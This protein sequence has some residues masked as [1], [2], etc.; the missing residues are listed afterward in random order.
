MIIRSAFSCLTCNQKHVVRIGMG[1]EEKQIH[2]F[3]CLGCGEDMTIQLIT[4]YVNIR[5]WAEAVENAVITDEE[6]GIP[7]VNLEAN[8]LI[9][10]NQ[11]NSDH[12]FPRMKQMHEMAKAAEARG[13]DFS[14]LPL[15]GESRLY[16]PYRRPDYG[17]E[18]MELKKAWSLSLRKKER[19]AKNVLEQASL[20]YYSDA[21]PNGLPDWLWR[22]GLF[23]SER[24]HGQSL[25]A[26]LEEIRPLFGTKSMAAFIA[27]YNGQAKKRGER[28]REILNEYF[29][30]FSEFGQVYFLMQ[31]GQRIPNENV[32]S[33]ISF[34]KIRMFYGN[35]FELFSSSVDIIAYLNNI[36]QGRQFDTFENLTRQQY[37][38]LD[39]SGRFNAFA[40]NAALSGICEERDNQLRNASHHGSLRLDTATQLIAMRAGKGGQGEETT[41]SYAKYLEKSSNLMLQ[42]ISLIRF[43]L[44]IYQIEKCE[45][46][47]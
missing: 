15:G 45:T 43:E 8:F 37:L 23:I 35:A 11:R 47:I 10:E 28:Y 4:D 19:L 36:K 31:A 13:L 5:A 12:A 33:S 32:I 30:N 2:K 40:A 20:T 3:A 21:P 18:W 27:D 14:R 42:I 34:S 1:Q 22:F 44:A 38:S 29:E 16:R 7:I 6:N 9:P 25:K 46:I 39:K 41:I 17:A 26:A 24:S